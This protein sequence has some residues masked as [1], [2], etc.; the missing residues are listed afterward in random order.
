MCE[1]KPKSSNDI[2]VASC[3]YTELLITC[4][5]FAIFEG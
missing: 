2:L 1:P 4:R 5:N 3:N